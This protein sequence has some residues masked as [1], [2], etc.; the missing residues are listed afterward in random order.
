MLLKFLGADRTVTGSCH[1]LQI[2]GLRVLLD[3]GLYQGPREESRRLNALL[4]ADPKSIDAVILSH[5]HLDHCG[6]LPALVKAGY[7]G[8]IY[9]TAPT[10]D[11]ARI[12][13]NDS[14]KIQEEDAAYLNRR[15]TGPESDAIKPIYGYADVGPVLNAFERVERGSRFELGGGMLAVTLFDAGHILGSCYVY[16]E[17]SENNQKR[18]LLFTADVGRYNAPI[19]NDPQPPPG[20]VDY[21]I[22]EST[23]GGRVHGPIE[24]VE[25][26]LLEAVRQTITKKSRLILPAFAMG[27]SQTM[28][29]YI[30]KFI[31][32]KKIDPIRIY[33]DSPM[34]VELTRVH[35]KYR[36]N[37][38]SQTLGLI[39][40]AG[41]FDRSNVTLAATGQDSRKINDDRG[42][43]VI[44]AS[45]P[46]CEFGR[47]LHHLKQSLENPNDMVLF[48]GFIPPN[49]LGR[50]LQDGQKRVTV[51]DRWYDVKCQ[52]KT[53]HGL[54]AHADG[55]ELMRFLAP[56]LSSNTSTFVVHG[57][58]DQ[59]EAFAAR[60]LEAGVRS[61]TIPAMDTAMYT[62]LAEAPLPRTNAP[63][64]TD[65]D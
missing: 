46:T 34:G 37:Y 41:L 59:S 5:G 12:I 40:G 35:E 52:V 23:Y 51:L 2:G 45:S 63:A 29:W 10:A 25:P 9:C 56:A 60:L 65:N 7:R 61:A 31:I 58:V 27:R 4:P 21:L 3:C 17:W 57:E 16:C 1:E 33:I 42:P 39:G 22:T 14:A 13:L 64:K 18:T 36:Q 8:K 49:T 55:D 30:Q 43:C 44:I 32:E 26:Q 15:S 50:R 19:L 54:S 38:D 24:A 62:S 11:V 20:P 47:V 53:V 48:C 6:R 28:L